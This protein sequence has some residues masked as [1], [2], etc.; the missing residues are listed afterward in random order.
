VSPYAE[1]E[2]DWVGTPEGS[3][4][5]LQIGIEDG[6]PRGL[7]TPSPLAERIRTGCVYEWQPPNTFG[8]L[9]TRDDPRIRWR[10]RRVLAPI[11]VQWAP[12]A[13]SMWLLAGKESACRARR[14]YGVDRCTGHAALTPGWPAF[15]A[16]YRAELERRSLAERFG[17][18]RQ[19]LVWLHTYPSVTILSLERGMPK[20]EA[21]L[22]WEQ[23]GEFVPWAQRH[24][25]REWLVSLLPLAGAG[26]TSR[27]EGGTFGG[28]SRGGSPQR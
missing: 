1:T 28:A 12:Y 19:V 24:I 27:A 17:M 8:V 3:I 25:F 9:V 4:A 10:A 26:A 18:L 6:C 16:A 2:L 23:R 21:L 20:G 22:A 14:C 11:H 15:A 13:P 5:R 7:L